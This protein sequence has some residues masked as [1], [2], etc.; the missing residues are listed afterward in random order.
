MR[1]EGRLG[2]AEAAP[3]R[4]L[5]RRAGGDAARRDG[6]QSNSF[7]G[8]RGSAASE[9]VASRDVGTST[10]RSTDQHL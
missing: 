1:I 2:E 9:A 7:G 4:T 3:V 10:Q 6:R 5:P 8:G